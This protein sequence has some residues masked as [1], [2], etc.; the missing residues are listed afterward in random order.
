MSATSIFVVEC[1]ISVI[2][3]YHLVFEILVQFIYVG[4]ETIPFQFVYSIAI[5]MGHRLEEFDAH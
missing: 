2:E 3:K 4:F 5:Y 1:E